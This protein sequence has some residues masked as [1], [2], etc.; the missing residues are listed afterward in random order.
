MRLPGGLLD[1]NAASS[2]EDTIRK[3]ARS[4][5]LVSQRIRGEMVLNKWKFDIVHN[6]P[7]FLHGPLD[8]GIVRRRASQPRRIAIH[9]LRNHQ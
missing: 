9:D 2:D 5:F 7:G 1:V 4:D 8:Y 6:F 3:V